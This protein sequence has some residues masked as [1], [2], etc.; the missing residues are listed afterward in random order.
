MIRTCDWG[1]VD[2]CAKEMAGNHRHFDSFAWH[3]RPDESEI[4]AVIYTHQRDSGLLDQS[5]AD[6]IAKELEPFTEG[7]SPD[8]VSERHSHWAVGWVEGYAIRVYRQEHIPSDGFADGGEFYSEEECLEI[9]DA[10]KA[11]CALQASLQDYPVLDEEDYSRREYEATIENI[12]SEGRRHV[13]S[14]APKDWASQVF[15]WISDREEYS[16]ELENRDGQG[17]YP[18]KETIRLALRDLALL[19]A[20][21][22]VVIEK[23]CFLETDN[24][25]KAQRAFD[26]LAYHA[27]IGIGQANGKTV[28]L[29][30]DDEVIDAVD[31]NERSHS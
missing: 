9:T 12:Q 1:D 21:Y 26:N 16:R 27:S 3:D 14:E 17:G 11:Y 25:A 7:D 18:N 6:A 10:F 8:V 4:W 30:E 31:G 2:S 24:L 23:N 5:N 19:D 22:Q 20:I 15:S 29:Y 13:K 28:E